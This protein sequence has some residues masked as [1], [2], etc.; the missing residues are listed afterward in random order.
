MNALNFNQEVYE[1]EVRE[2]T[3]V[4]ASPHYGAARRISNAIDMAIRVEVEAHLGHYVK[5]LYTVGYR[6]DDITP[7]DEKKET[8]TL[9]VSITLSSP[10]TLWD[11]T[12]QALIDRWPSLSQ[13]LKVNKVETRHDST[14]TTDVVVARNVIVQF[15]DPK[16]VVTP[17][18]RYHRAFYG[19]R[20][21]ETGYI[22]AIRK[23]AVETV[24]ETP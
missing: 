10:A 5:C 7:I 20:D 13:W 4:V 23:Q 17:T 11:S 12:K 24:K 19:R 14:V 22:E 18:G 21:D 2:V 9:P 6:N 15:V 1:Y 8:V 3:F 16:L